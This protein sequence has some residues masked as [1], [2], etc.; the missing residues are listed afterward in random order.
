M[1]SDDVRPTLDTLTVHA[2]SYDDPGTGAVVTPIH[3]STTY[4]YPHGDCPLRYSRYGNNPTQ[5]A[6]HRRLAAIE[7]TEDALIL[8]SGMAALAT[9]ILATCEAGDHVAA[10]SDLYGGTRTLLADELPRLGIETTF[11]EN[12]DPGAWEEAIRP[13]TRLMLWE[14]I[15]NPLLRVA[16]GEALAGIGRERGIVTLVDATFATPVLQRPAAFGADLVMHSATKYLGGHS[17][18]IGGVLA[19]SAERIGAATGRMKHFGGSPDPAAVFLLERG[20]KTLALRVA[21]HDANGREVAAFLAGHPKVERVWHPSRPDHPDREVADRVLAGAG[22]G[23]VT[24]APGAT[25]E[26]TEAMVARLR[27][28]RVAP[29]LG[30]VE[31]LVSMPSLTSHRGLEPAERARLGIPEHAVRLALGIEAASD[32]VDDLDRALASL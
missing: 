27:W 16:D 10:S 4:V 28:I 25:A 15:S 13:E 8:S 20:L 21:R 19:G 11:V 9:A 18:L 26:E 24:F 6:V 31:S 22:G 5:E 14:S 12:P 3:R 7:G 32:L 29:S 23:V 30:G 1:R 17:D 2:G